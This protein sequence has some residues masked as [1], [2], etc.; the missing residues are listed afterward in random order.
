MASGVNKRVGLSSR[1]NKT[2]INYKFGSMISM[3]SPD[4]PIKAQPNTTAYSPRQ[5]KQK[6]Y[7]PP[8][9]LQSFEP[10]KM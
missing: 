7:E 5:F 4:E 8:S 1:Y 10:N 9:K 3:R 6:T 2:D